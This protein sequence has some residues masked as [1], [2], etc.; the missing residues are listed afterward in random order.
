MR[1][2]EP[3]TPNTAAAHVMARRYPEELAHM[4]Q[5]AR[6]SSLLFEAFEALHHLDA[7][8]HEL[9][10]C[11]AILHDIGLS[12]GF[13]G[14]HKHSRDLILSSDLTPL[15]QAERLVVANIARYHRKAAPSGAHA[16]FAALSTGQ[17]EV[18]RGVAPLLRLADG[19]DRAH[20]EAV[21]SLSA[22]KRSAGQWE[23]RIEGDGNLD[24]AVW[25]AKRKAGLFDETYGVGLAM[26]IAG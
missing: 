23:L 7:T 6:L 10:W 26:D 15:D 19:L 11:G 2:P 5:V 4:R 14:H 21:A 13:K 17:R 25:G 8:A 22:V 12:L 1:S 18:V 20:E 24:F 16:A 9:L 3:R